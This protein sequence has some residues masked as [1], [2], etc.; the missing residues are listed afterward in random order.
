[1]NPVAK[2]LAIHAADPRSRA[3]IHPI[4][5]PSKR[6]KPPALVDVLNPPREPPKLFRQIILRA[7]SPLMARP[8]LHA[9][10]NQPH[11]DS[12]IPLSVSQQSL[13]YYSVAFER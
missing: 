4:T 9:A 8:H 6:Q 11:C 7:I 1:M 3:A 12:G 13:W 10:L 2:R 5:D